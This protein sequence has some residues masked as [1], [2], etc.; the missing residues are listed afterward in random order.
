MLRGVIW[1]LF[2]E[3]W[4]KVKNF[5]RLNHLQN[6]G[7]KKYLKDLLFIKFCTAFL[8]LEA[9]M[10]NGFGLRTSLKKSWPL[11]AKYDKHW[12]KSENF[13][14]EF[15]LYF[16]PFFQSF[17]NLMYFVFY[18]SSFSISRHVLG[19]KLPSILQIDHKFLFC[20]LWQIC[21]NPIYSSSQQRLVQQFYVLTLNFEIPQV[22]YF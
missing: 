19:F 3:I 5:L 10:K 20:F 16:V 18:T 6:N 12:Q 1:H 22:A 17:R 7:V 15:D 4:A 9:I 13:K 8:K 14:F 21:H 2:L 11:M